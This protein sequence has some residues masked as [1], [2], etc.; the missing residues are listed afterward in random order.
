M[1]ADTVLECTRRL[2]RKKGWS[3]E[4]AYEYCL[5]NEFRERRKEKW[6]D[7]ELVK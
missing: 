6:G 2:V 7:S 4:R 3:E 5:T 1:R